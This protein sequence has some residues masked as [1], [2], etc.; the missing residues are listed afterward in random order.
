M[1]F[2]ILL[3]SLL[4]GEKKEKISIRRCLWY[5]PV[6]AYELMLLIIDKEFAEALF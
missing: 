6:F 2:Y 4:V 5:N 3:E 1:L